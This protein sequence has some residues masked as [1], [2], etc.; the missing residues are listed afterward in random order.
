MKLNNFYTN[1]NIILV[2]ICI[3]NLHMLSNTELVS[4]IEEFAIANSEMDLCKNWYLLLLKLTIGKHLMKF[5]II[6]NSISGKIS[7]TN[8]KSKVVLS[9]LKVSSD[10][11]INM[12]IHKFIQISS[13]ESKP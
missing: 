1:I 2:F 13:L 7:C 9:Y 8:S 3:C 6:S 4:D 12:S 11:L 10:I 5:S